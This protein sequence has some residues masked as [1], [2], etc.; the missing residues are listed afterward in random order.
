MPPDTTKI[1]FLEAIGKVK[2]YKKDMQVVCD[3]LLYS[4]LDSLARLYKEPVIYQ[5]V[6]RQYTA[7]SVTLV[8]EGGGMDKASLM[9]NAFIAIQEDTS[10]YD[11]I[12]GAEMMAYFDEKGALERF[13]VLGGASALFYIEEN[14]VFATVNKPESKML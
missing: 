4:D 8:I 11:Q 6:V 7:D 5:E 3:S 14:D 2:I 9:S 10:H 12:K 1:G 13:D